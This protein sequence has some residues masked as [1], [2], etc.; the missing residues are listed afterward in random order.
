MESARKEN[1]FPAPDDLFQNLADE[2]NRQRPDSVVN[3]TKIEGGE[4][5]LSST[6]KS[7]PICYESIGHAVYST[8]LHPP[9][10][11]ANARA[12]V[13]SLMRLQKELQKGATRLQG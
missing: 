4:Q 7:P 11:E 2:E 12:V 6:R 1:A 10:Y 5:S 9:I 8:F 13:V 3:F